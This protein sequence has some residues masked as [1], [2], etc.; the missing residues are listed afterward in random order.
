MTKT[1]P[2]GSGPSPTQRM[3][4]I[5]VG[6][7]AE[8]AVFAAVTL[9]IPELLA[10]GDGDLDALVAATGCDPSALRRLMDYLVALDVCE[11]DGPGYRLAPMG[12]VLHPDTAGSVRDYVLLAGQEFHAVWGE[13]LHTLRSGRPSFDHV[14]GTDLYAYMAAHPE[15]GRRFDGAMNSGRSV[16]EAVARSFDFGGVGTVV[17]IGGGNGE[18]L[19]D[20]LTAH[21]AVSGVLLEVPSAIEGAAAY[22]DGRGPD[23][24]DLGKRCEFVAGDMFDKVPAGGDAYVLSRVL[25][26]WDDDKVLRLL[27]NCA[28]A[29]APGGRVLIVERPQLEGAPSPVASAIDL[30]MMLVTSGGKSRSGAELGEL[31]DAAGLVLDETHELT[32]GFQL[33]VARRP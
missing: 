15:A 13:V 33:L 4:E 11:Q 12:R 32:Q 6:S 17:D 24:E 3:M 16:F 23:G 10:Q 2:V 21:P 9:G 8:R 22:L 1:P 7:W 5:I 27:G 18:L 29:M 25:V 19:V 26:N 14:Y 28:A 20:V 31:L 30:L